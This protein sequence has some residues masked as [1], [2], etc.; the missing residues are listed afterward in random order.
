MKRFNNDP[1]WALAALLWSFAISL[2]TTSATYAGPQGSTIKPRVDVPKGAHVDPFHP[3]F[4]FAKTDGV[5]MGTACSCAAVTGSRGEVMTFT[6]ASSGTCMKGDWDSSIANG[7]MVTCLTNQPR[8]MP[9]GDGTGALGLYIEGA[10]TNS[11]L[12]SENFDDAAWTKDQDAA[13]RTPT[14][15]ANQAIAPDGTLT[16]DRIIVPVTT[17]GQYSQVFGTCPNA[18]STASVFVKGVSGS[19]TFDIAA[20][21][22]GVGAT[23]TACS[24]NPTTWTRCA[25]TGSGG[26]DNI[27]V[28]SNA[29]YGGNCLGAAADVYVWGGQCEAGEF[30]SSYIATAGIAVTRAVDVANVAYSPASTLSGSIAGTFIPEGQAASQETTVAAASTATYDRLLLYNT[31]VAKARLHSSAGPAAE[32]AVTALPTLGAANRL[33]G[34][35]VGADLSVT[36]LGSTGTATGAV[37]GTHDRMSIGQYNSGT[38]PAYGVVKS[39]CVDAES[40]T[41]CQ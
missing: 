12:Q 11:T 30:A 5:G 14:V 26:V 31:G 7:D 41:R 27:I 18:A 19:G 38:G 35:W 24:Y 3:T 10:R 16:A 33:S 21:E 34:F 4:E 23:C 8:V 6:R 32:T 40:T 28:G 13:P 17:G 37:P 39:V 25:V 9:G 36:F 22:A 20:F 29:V 1:W 15:S 2:V